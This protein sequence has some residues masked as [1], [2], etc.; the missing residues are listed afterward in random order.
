MAKKNARF[1]VE[2]KLGRTDDEWEVID[3][4]IEQLLEMLYA[5]DEDS[6]DFTRS[7]NLAHG[8]VKAGLEVSAVA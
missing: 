5:I 3:R 8:K 1:T 4:A 2:F 7:I 6:S